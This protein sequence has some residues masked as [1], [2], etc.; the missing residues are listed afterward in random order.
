MGSA[1]SQELVINPDTAPTGM[2]PLSVV[3][4]E[5]YSLTI[6]WPTLSTTLNGGDDPYYYRVEWF[7]NNTNSW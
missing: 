7:N 5:P 6:S 3:S 2:D 4:V 1:Y